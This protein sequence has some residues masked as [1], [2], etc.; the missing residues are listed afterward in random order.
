METETKAVISPVRSH[1][2][3]VVLYEYAMTEE[4]KIQNYVSLYIGIG[5][6]LLRSRKFQMK[7][8]PEVVVIV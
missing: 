8:S 7:F 5:S 1:R 4:Q 6:P 2:R 3:L